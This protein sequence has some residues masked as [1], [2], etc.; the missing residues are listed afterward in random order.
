[1]SN[2]ALIGDDVFVLWMPYRRGRLLVAPPD[3]KIFFC[4]VF[5]VSC[6]NCCVNKR[7]FKEPAVGGYI[8]CNGMS[9]ADLSPSILFL[10]EASA[11]GVASLLNA[12]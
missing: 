12:S 9:F 11:S 6:R 2:V 5:S 4:A 7:N 3:T 10:V 1:M 8:L